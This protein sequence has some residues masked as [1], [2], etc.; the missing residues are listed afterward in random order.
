MAEPPSRAA[1]DAMIERAYPD[2]PE[3]ERQALARAWS[4]LARWV[5][6]LPRDLPYEDEPATIFVAPERQGR[7]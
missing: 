5:D 6:L 7:R 2:L 3:A 4:H 1:V